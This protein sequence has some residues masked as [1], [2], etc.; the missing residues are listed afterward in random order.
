ML[1]KG[2]CQKWLYLYSLDEQEDDDTF[3]RS[4]Y[5]KGRSCLQVETE[6]LELGM[7]TLK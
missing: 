5:L 6:Y 3:K 1:G 7:L 4:E 2:W